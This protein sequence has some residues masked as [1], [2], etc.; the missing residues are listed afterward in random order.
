LIGFDFSTLWKRKNNKNQNES[1]LFKNNPINETT[2]N[3]M[4]NVLPGQRLGVKMVTNNA[5]KS[6]YQKLNG[7]M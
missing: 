2:V 7:G 1:I 6:L 4:S 5:I 3:N